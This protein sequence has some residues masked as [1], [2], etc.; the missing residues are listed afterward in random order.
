[1][2]PTVAFVESGNAC[3]APFTLVTVT[4]GSTASMTRFM[5][6]SDPLVPGTGRVRAA[7]LPARSAIAP[8]LSVNEAAAT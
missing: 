4:T 2:D 8:P 7:G 5:A 1:M 6:L 3:T